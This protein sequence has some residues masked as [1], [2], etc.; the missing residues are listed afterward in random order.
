MFSSKCQVLAASSGQYCSNCA[1]MKRNKVKRRQRKEN[2]DQG[3]PSSHANHHYMSDQE[4]ATK[5]LEQKIYLKNCQAREIDIRK[6]LRRNC[7]IWNRMTIT[8]YC[9]CSKFV[10]PTK[11]IADMQ[12]FWEQQKKILQTSSKQGYRWH[13]K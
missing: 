12:L 3:Q 2:S 1:L 11:E 8:N 4:I 6:N 7:W 13:P 5:L 10:Q 9:V